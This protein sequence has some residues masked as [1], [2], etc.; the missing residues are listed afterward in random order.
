MTQEDVLRALIDSHVM[1]HAYYHADDAFLDIIDLA[2]ESLQPESAR[3]E[4]Q[5]K[6]EI[7]G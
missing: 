7:W 2:I 6:L 4:D 5:R 3:I 1:V